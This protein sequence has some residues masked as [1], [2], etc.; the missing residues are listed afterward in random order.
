MRSIEQG[1]VATVDRNAIGHVL[2]SLSHPEE[3][4]K[5]PSN[6]CHHEVRPYAIGYC[7]MRD[8]THHCFAPLGGLEDAGHRWRE[9]QHQQLEFSS[10]IRKD[11]QPTSV[12]GADSLA[13]CLAWCLEAAGGPCSPHSSTSRPLK[14]SRKVCSTACFLRPEAL[15][16]GGGVAQACGSTNSTSDACARCFSSSVS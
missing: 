7:I 4:S 8:S 9:D 10:C 11:E 13:G 1:T 12:S 6:F 2:C 16:R 15:G 14:R 3:H 5:N